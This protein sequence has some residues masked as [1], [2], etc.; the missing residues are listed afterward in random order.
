MNANL[1]VLRG[2]LAATARRVAE[3]D[4]RYHTVRLSFTRKTEPFLRVVTPLTH[5]ERTVFFPPEKSNS[6]AGT[7]LPHKYK[8]NSLN[9]QGHRGHRRNTAS[10]SP[11]CEHK[12]LNKNQ[13]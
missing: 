6:P 4:G 9:A 11:P 7:G 3:K 1:C 10:P 12:G 13:W 5:V 2:R 8:A